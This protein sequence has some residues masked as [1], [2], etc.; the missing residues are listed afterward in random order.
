MDTGAVAGGR[1]AAR[2]WTL[3]R[4][5]MSDL[6]RYRALDHDTCAAKLIVSPG[7]VA[8]MH[9]R[10]GHWLWSRP[11]RDGPLRTIAKAVYLVANRG[12]E[13]FTRISIAPRASIG[14]GLYL[15]HVGGIIVGDGVVIGSDCT[16]S[17]DV[18]LGVAGRTRRGSPH[19]GDRV[20]FAPGAKAFGPITIGSDATIGA[21][22]VVTRSVPDRSVSVGV[23]ARTVSH[24]S[25]FGSFIYEDMGDDPERAASLALQGKTPID[26]ATVPPASRDSGV[27]PRG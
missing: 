20:F 2:H 11:G 12:A 14:P 24:D 15:D 25:R 26:P 9:Y 16:L 7:T 27:G 21:N 23:P 5:I 10:L 13:A 8:S 18:T 1:P 6:H 3:R 4:L 22:A 19:L 17:H